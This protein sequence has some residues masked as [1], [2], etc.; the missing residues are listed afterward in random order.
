MNSVIPNRI[1]GRKNFT[2]EMS[3]IVKGRR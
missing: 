1:K 2:Q 3:N